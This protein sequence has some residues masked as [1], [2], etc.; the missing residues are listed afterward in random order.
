MPLRQYSLAAVGALVGSLLHG[1]LAGS[2]NATNTLSLKP[3]QDAMLT[4][5]QELA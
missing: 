1:A 4:L 5:M 3:L 2:G